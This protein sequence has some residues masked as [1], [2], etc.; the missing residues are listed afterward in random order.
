LKF[1]ANVI[2]L[3]NQAIVT[4]RTTR[5]NRNGNL[6][7]SA[8]QFFSGFNAPALVHPLNGSAPALNPI[9]NLPSAYQGIREMRLGVHLEF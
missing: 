6:A 1:D 3:F 5:L 8:E 4:G 7:L 9:Y 2:N